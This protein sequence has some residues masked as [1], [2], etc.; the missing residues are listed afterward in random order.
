M[1]CFVGESLFYRVGGAGSVWIL[2]FVSLVGL[3]LLN[4]YERLGGVEGEGENALD[5][6]GVRVVELK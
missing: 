5:F 1:D 6:S 4:R 2:I 3:T